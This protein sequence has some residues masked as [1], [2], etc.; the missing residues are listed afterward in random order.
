MIMLL[1]W[2][3]M[4]LVLQ[5]SV[6]CMFSMYLSRFEKSYILPEPLAYNIMTPVNRWLM[7][8]HSNNNK[9]CSWDCTRG[10][11]DKKLTS[12]LV[13]RTFLIFELANIV[14]K[15]GSR[16]FFKK[17]KT[18]FDFHPHRH[19]RSKHDPLDP[20]FYHYVVSPPERPHFM[21]L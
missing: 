11:T 9:Y 19:W 3:K 5:L 18:N 20:A 8:I 13:I 16:L 6:I 21:V 4:L 15:Y 7:R 10:Q 17:A 12:T 2:K 1:P 14:L